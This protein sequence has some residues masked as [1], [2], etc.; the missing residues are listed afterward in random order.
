M[1]TYEIV[2][3]LLIALAFTFTFLTVYFFIKYEENNRPLYRKIDLI[4]ANSVIIFWICLV[5]MSAK[6]INNDAKPITTNECMQE[7]ED[8]K[9]QS[10]PFCIS[11]TKWQKQRNRE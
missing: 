7:V 2:R 3:T 5:C 6:Y 10:P 11:F 1:S 4:C 8:T 9:N